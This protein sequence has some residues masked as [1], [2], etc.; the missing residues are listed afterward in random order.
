MSMEPVAPMCCWAKWRSPC[1][2]P[3]RAVLSVMVT[4]QPAQ[5]RH[6][7]SQ[8]GPL[9]RT[10]HR[11]Q[12]RS[13]PTWMG[14]PGR[15]HVGSAWAA[16]LPP[17]PT[18]PR[19]TRPRVRTMASTRQSRVCR[20]G[21]HTI[22]LY[23][24][25]AAGG[26]ENPLIGILTA[27]SPSG[28]PVGHLDAVSDAG[29]AI[30]ITGWA[31]DPDLATKGLEIHAYV[32]G[33]AGDSKARGVNL[34]Y[35]TVSRPDVATVH[36][37]AGPAHGFDVTIKEP[38]L[39]AHVVYVYAIDAKAP[40]NNVLLG[41]KT[42]TVTE[43]KVPVAPACRTADSRG[44]PWAAWNGYEPNDSAVRP[45]SSGGNMCPVTPPTGCACSGPSS[46]I[47][48]R[49]RRTTCGWPR[50]PRGSRWRFAPLAR[51]ARVLWSVARFG[52]R[53]ARADPGLGASSVRV[54]SSPHER[55]F[56]DE[57]RS[58]GTPVRRA[59]CRHRFVRILDD[60]GAGTTGRRVVGFRQRPDGRHRL[61]ICRAAG[62]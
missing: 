19:P 59:H 1:R 36:P 46:G 38:A 4:R 12:W 43:P 54:R 48:Y 62:G 18:L 56:C 5:S 49:R 22:F 61:V 45:S 28:S 41:S 26:G 27:T 24:I 42:V 2:G 7:R 60:V 55:G 8:G 13:T 6:P 32:N 44:H 47:G 9:T 31:V 10:P 14:Q 35:A 57:V 25:N 16:P 17:G 11:P 29:A 23:A 53:R 21:P 30:R 52:S 58:F 51:L 40:G 15:G 20:P 34:G 50:R 33:P 37:G 3:Q 39:G